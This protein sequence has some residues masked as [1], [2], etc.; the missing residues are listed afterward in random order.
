MRFAVF[1]SL[2]LV[3]SAPAPGHAA[4]TEAI[5]PAEVG[6]LLDDA[7][8]AWIQLDERRF[9][10]AADTLG[11]RI[12]CLDAA[13]DHALV[14]RYHQLQGMRAFLARDAPR[15]RLAFAAARRVHPPTGLSPSLVPERHPL[16]EEYTAMPL[17][18]ISLT[19]VPRPAAGALWFDATASTDRPANVPTL[20]QWQDARGAIRRTAYVWPD[21][22]LPA[23]PVAGAARRSLLIVAAASGIAAAGLYTGAGLTAATYHDPVTPRDDLGG[24]RTRVNVLNGA[25]IVVGVAAG[26]AAVTAFTFPGGR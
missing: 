24:L 9:E 12:A 18:A 20:F 7:E 14:A 1:G 25:A 11:G 3:V 6:L 17:E 2:L 16:R 19:R 26:G 5:T 21:A 23:Y 13:P 10:D 15:S 4:C 22:P 8:A